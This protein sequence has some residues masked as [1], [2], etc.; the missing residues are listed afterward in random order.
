MSSGEDLV[1]GFD[2]VPIRDI[3]SESIQGFGRFAVDEHNERG[4]E[5]LEFIRVLNGLERG[6]RYGRIVFTLVLLAK[7]SREIEWTYIAKVFYN[8][9]AA[10]LLLDWNSVLPEYN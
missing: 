3:D 10:L 5:R 9:R 1:P 6:Q 7:T 8:Q 2:P 4:G